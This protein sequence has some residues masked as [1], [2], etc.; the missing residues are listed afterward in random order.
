MA[1]IERPQGRTR[2][3]SDKTDHHPH[4]VLVPTE[5]KPYK[6]GI[7]GLGEPQYQPESVRIKGFCGEIIESVDHYRHY[8][9]TV[10]FPAAKKHGVTRIIDRVIMKAG[11]FLPSE[12]LEFPMATEAV[13]HLGGQWE[14][15]DWAMNGV[16]LPGRQLTGATRRQLLTQAREAG[17]LSFAPPQALP[18]GFTM[19]KISASLPEKDMADLSA[20]FRQSFNGYLTPLETPEQV[21]AWLSGEDMYPVAVRN[22]DGQIVVVAS[23][24]IARMTFDAREFR[25]FEIGDSAAHPDYRS[26]GINRHIKHFLLSEAAKMHFD[27][28]HTETRAAWKAPNFANSKNGMT[29][30][31]TLWSNCQ[32]SGPE[33]IP[34]T[35]DPNL[36][37]D[38]RRM[39]SLNIWSMT[40]SN[41]LWRYYEDYIE[42][43]L[44]R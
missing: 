31:G 5:K 8:L 29:Y 22:E 6:P 13:V 9:Q 2:K 1:H 39:G 43:E 42:A 44:S 3:S 11:L 34:E 10:V 12:G 35:S 25:F 40:Q 17:Q 20:I 27:S 37:Q 18:E 14:G 38:S 41:P 32:I 30:G 7:G 4:L 15:Y 36:N 26:Q 28:I 19:E 33:D 21:K 24:D 23:G 16:S